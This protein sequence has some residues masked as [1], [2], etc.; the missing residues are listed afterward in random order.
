MYPALIS[1]LPILSF[2][3][4]VPAS[5]WVG[6]LV[7]ALGAVGLTTLATEWVRSRGKAQQ[8]KLVKKWGALPTVALL[9]HDGTGSP[10]TRARRRRALELVTK[11]ELP[12]VELELRDPIAADE[13]IQSLVKVAIATV[14]DKSDA[15]VLHS[16]V[17]SYGFRRNLRALKP[18]AA[19]VILLSIVG[20]VLA[21]RYSQEPWLPWI[22][23][24]VLGLWLLIWLTVITDRWVKEAADEYADQFFA[25]LESEAAK[26][27]KRK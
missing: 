7:P 15:S 25:A 17:V 11:S 18:L 12:G 16:E 14:R 9:R 20:V 1:A 21:G 5:P 13:E 8:R 2:L 3:V 24:G 10:A 19:A 4:W 26:T 27:Q 23:A 22:V 6:T